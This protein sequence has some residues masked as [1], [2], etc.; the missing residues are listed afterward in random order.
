VGAFKWRHLMTD[1]VGYYA[2]FY[3]PQ[4]NTGSDIVDIYSLLEHDPVTA[5]VS[6]LTAFA[7]QPDDTTTSMRDFAIDSD[8]FYFSTVDF[9][10]G[11]AAVWRWVR[12]EL[13][14]DN[15]WSATLTGT[16]PSVMID[17][18]NG[19]LVINMVSESPL[20]EKSYI[21]NP[22]TSEVTQLNLPG[23]GVKLSLQIHVVD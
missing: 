13:S 10:S 4:Y 18:D 6:T 5:D 2:G 20:V 9:V 14:A 11:Q 8:T 7:F 15:I 3:L 16:K 22:N 23:D 1:G 19:W 17:A 21:Y 12:G